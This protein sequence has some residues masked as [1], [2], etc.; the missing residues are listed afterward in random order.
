MLAAFEMKTVFRGD[1]IDGLGVDVD[2]Q[3]QQLGLSRCEA[4]QLFVTPFQK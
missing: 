3:I 4:V 1:G 2:Y